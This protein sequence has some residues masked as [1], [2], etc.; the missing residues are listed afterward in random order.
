MWLTCI[1]YCHFLTHSSFTQIIATHDVQINVLRAVPHMGNLGS[2]P[3][4]HLWRGSMSALTFGAGLAWKLEP[5]NECSVTELVMDWAVVLIYLELGLAYIMWCRPSL[6]VVVNCMFYICISTLKQIW[7]STQINNST[8]AISANSQ[9]LFHLFSCNGY[10][11]LHQHDSLL[12]RACL[13]T[14]STC[15]G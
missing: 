4:R 10:L 5:P 13:G 7:S 11:L 9:Q 6:A 15:A 8:I 14:L 1:F 2:R 12:L 3:G